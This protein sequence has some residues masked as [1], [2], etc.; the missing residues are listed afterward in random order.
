M[1]QTYLSV[2]FGS[3]ASH[4]KTCLLREWVREK[5][6]EDDSLHSFMN[7]LDCL[8]RH[9]PEFLLSKT[10]TVSS[11]PTKDE[12][13]KPLFQH[14]PNSGMLLDGALLTANTSESPSRAE[15]ST[16]SGVIETGEV[17]E[18]YFLSPN[19]AKGMLRRANKM[20]RNLFPPLKKSLE[21][22]TA[23]DQSTKG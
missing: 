1:Q 11:I 21:K 17:P 5:G 14:W 6:L 2:I 16:L 18:R 9:A 4:A 10:C 19:A 12:I 8:H 20:G 15:E 22:L 3:E 13:S 7:L 23:M